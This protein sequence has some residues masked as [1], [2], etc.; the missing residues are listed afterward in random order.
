MLWVGAT[1]SVPA[2]EK[3]DVSKKMGSIVEG[4]H[5]N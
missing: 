4:I 5:E 1:P 2:E 3:M